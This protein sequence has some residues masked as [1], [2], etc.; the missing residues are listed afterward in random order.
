MASSLDPLWEHDPTT[1]IILM[2]LESFG[3][4]Q[5]FL[6]LCRRVARTKPIL[7]VKSGRTAAGARAAASHT[8]SLAGAEQA[9]DS[10]FTQSGVIRAASIE[11]LFVYAS[12]F[13]SQPIPNGKRVAIVTNSGGPGILATDACIQLGLDIPTLSDATQARM[14]AVVPDP[15]FV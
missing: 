13:A 11:E 9:V 7:A 12:A 2:Y 14:R 1:R 6:Q 8:G 5:K 15:A 4:P 10:L 3:N